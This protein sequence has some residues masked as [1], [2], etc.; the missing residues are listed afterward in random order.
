RQIERVEDEHGLADRQVDAVGN[1]APFD[2]DR[3][4][5]GLQPFAAAGRAGPKRPVRLEILLLEPAAFLVA[6]PEIR[7]QPFEAGAERILLFAALPLFPRRLG[8]GPARAAAG[9][10]EQQVAD[11]L[12]QPAERRREVDPERLAQGRE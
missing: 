12:R 11:L 5:L 6:A 9:A 10:K 2:L 8:L 1:R 7:D 3:A 4:A